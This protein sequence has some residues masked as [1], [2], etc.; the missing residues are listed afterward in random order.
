MDRQSPVRLLFGGDFAPRG[1]Y[2]KLIFDKGGDIF[3]NAL[4]LID[5]ADF[6][7]VN[8]EAPLRV[9]GS[10]IRKIGPAM[11]IVP[12]ALQ[13]LNQAGIDAVCLANNHIFDYGRDGLAQTRTAL[14]VRGIRYAGAG[15]D[16]LSAESPLRIKLK[17]RHVSI[18]SVAEREFN[19]SDDGQ[20]GAALLDPISLTPLIM[21]ERTQADAIVICVHGGNEYFPLPRPG[22]RRLFHY[23]VD[24]GA[25]AIMGHHPHVPGAYEVYKGKP[26]VYSLGNLIFDSAVPPPEWESGYFACL[27]LD[28]NDTGL[29]HIRI[30]LHPYHQAASKD[31]M[32][33]LQ[34]HA[35]DDFLARIE[36]MRDQL[37]NHPQKWLDAWKAFVRNK[38]AQAMID[39]SSPVRFRGFRRL[40]RW[41]FMRDLVVS[42]TRR[43]H[44]LN[45]M[46][47]A[48]HQE[49]VVS[50]LENFQEA[51]RA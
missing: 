4:E 50:A 32:Q 42:P 12:E 24:I 23:L 43:L 40:M 9:E 49:L 16:R 22:L 13:A 34:G 3:G 8:L 26:I 15:P 5:Q 46:R 1:P 30:E 35:R 47:C 14:D 21:Q 25:D 19:I 27:D 7:M 6:T 33:L 29:E 10:A 48:S 51:E 36:E 39:L 37:E 18:F 17:E 44:R 11:H 38:Q 31:G 2:E 28:F 20:A 41:K 45:L